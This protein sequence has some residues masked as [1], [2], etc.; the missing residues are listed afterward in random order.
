MKFFGTTL[1]VCI[2]LAAVVVS[3]RAQSAR[4]YDTSGRLV[5]TTNDGA[6]RT[7]DGRLLRLHSKR[8]NVSKTYDT[9]GRLL[10]IGI[11]RGNVQ[12]VYDTRGRLIGRGFYNTGRFY[13]AHGRYVA[14]VR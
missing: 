2:A 6:S 8:G 11:K 13:D 7:P 10:N 14:T 9:N 3:A 12:Y 4:G 5:F 1:I